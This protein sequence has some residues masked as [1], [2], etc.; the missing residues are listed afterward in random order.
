MAK[1]RF[2]SKAVEDLTSI[3]NY[4]CRTW[5]E[6]QADEYYNML[7]AACRKIVDNTFRLA[8]SYGDI[9]IVR[10]LR[11]RMDVKCHLGD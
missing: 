1:I 4:T 11:E 9:L 7:V 2:S 6:R 3:W 10:I 5:S 8:K